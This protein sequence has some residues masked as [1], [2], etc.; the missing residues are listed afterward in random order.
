[1]YSGMLTYSEIFI[2]TGIKWLPQQ[3][4]GAHLHGPCSTCHVFQHLAGAW[5]HGCM[6]LRSPSP[7]TPALHP[8][9]L[10]RAAERIFYPNQSRKIKQMMKSAS[11]AVAAA[12]FHGLWGWVRVQHSRSL[13]AAQNQTTAALPARQRTLLLLL[14]ML[15]VNK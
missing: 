8:A 4:C 11:D 14:M 1:M 3:P 13:Q 2:K 7:P 10:H 6:A 12:G 9:Q 15:Y 5:L